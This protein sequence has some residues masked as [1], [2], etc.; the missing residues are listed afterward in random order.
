MEPHDA[1]DILRNIW[2]AD[3]DTTDGLD[4]ECNPNKTCRNMADVSFDG[5]AKEGGDL[6]AAWRTTLAREGKLTGTPLGQ[7]LYPDTH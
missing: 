2:A 5:Y 6:A 7:L 1:A 4:A 3:T